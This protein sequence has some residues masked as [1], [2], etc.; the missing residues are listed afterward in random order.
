MGLN[1]LKAK[2]QKESGFD[3]LVIIISQMIIRA[4]KAVFYTCAGFRGIFAHP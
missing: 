4:F 2:I 1:C 3:E